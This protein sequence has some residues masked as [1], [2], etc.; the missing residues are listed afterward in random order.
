MTSLVEAGSPGCSEAPAEGSAPHS[1][2]DGSRRAMS[3]PWLLALGVLGPLGPFIPLEYPQGPFQGLQPLKCR[4]QR[5]PAPLLPASG[6]DGGISPRSLSKPH[7]HLAACLLTLPALRPA[8]RRVSLT[9][10]C[11]SLYPGVHLPLWSVSVSVRHAPGVKGSCFPSRRRSSGV[12][13][14]GA[15]TRKKVFVCVGRGGEPWALTLGTDS[16]TV[17]HGG[18]AGNFCA[19]TGT[20]AVGRGGRSPHLGPPSRPSPSTALGSLSVKRGVC[21][22]MCVTAHTRCFR[23]GHAHTLTSH[24]RR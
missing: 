12:W 5:P 17:G 3:P 15:V 6:W 14:A 11:V 19:Q 4:F 23:R 24:T 21:T 1:L 20:Q 7:H 18:P 10:P 8:A 9:C 16:S 2:S 13:G 22:G